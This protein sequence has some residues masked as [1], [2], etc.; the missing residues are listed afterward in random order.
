MTPKL[1]IGSAFPHVELP[2][3]LGDVRSLA[4]IGSGQPLIVAFAR[5]WW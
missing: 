4:S 5:G 2:D 3:Q 1:A